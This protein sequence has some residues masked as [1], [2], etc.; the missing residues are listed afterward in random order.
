MRRGLP[1][2]AHLAVL[3]ALATAISGQVSGPGSFTVMTREGRR[4]LATTVVQGRELVGLNDLAAFFQLTVREDTAARAVTVTYKNRT[5]ILTPDQTLA[6]VAGRLISLPAPLTRQGNRWLVPIEFISRALEPIYDGRIELRAV[7]RLVIVGDVRV[8]RVTAQ[9]ETTGNS[10]RVAFEITPKA[11]TALI[12][13]QGRLLLRLDA[14][15]VDANIPPPPAQAPQGVLTAVR[16]AEPNSIQLDLGPRFTSYRMG[17]PTSEGASV[18]VVVEL[19]AATTETIAIPV[20]SPVPAGDPLTLIPS[21]RS[22]IRTVVIDPG[23]GGD[24]S[25]AK[26]AGGTL[27]KDVVLAVARRARTAIE[28]RL[29][30]RVLL[31]REEDNRADSD[32]RAAIANNN[33]ADLFISLHANAS[34]RA[35]TRGAQVMYLGLDRFGEA[36]RQRYESQRE[37]LPVY[38]GGTREIA[39]VQWELAQASHVYESTALANIV[40]KRLRDSAGI[41]AVT[42]QKG[43][44][45]AL[46]GA[47]MPAALIEMGYL[48]NP[49]EE[50]LLASGDFQNSIAQSLVEAV[51]SFR[52]YLERGPASEASAETDGPAR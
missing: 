12:Q 10:V 42:V 6:S 21:V 34:P 11:T 4:A 16:P 35:S 45:R 27:E 9:Y 7:S 24:D 43:P 5:I 47:N 1:Y 29:G 22:A 25:G 28:G 26:G 13:E 49:E 23:H 17:T 8:P 46:A 37:A 33:K 41:S 40:E 19:L 20:P 38:G 51:I 32:A 2:L 39:L 50:R 30:L 3:L 31:T 52:D 48:S 44:L 14:D 36:A 15:A 18:Y